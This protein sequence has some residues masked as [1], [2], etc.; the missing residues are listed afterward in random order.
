MIDPSTNGRNQ[1]EG[2]NIPATFVAQMG[3]IN[4]PGP[5]RNNLAE[6]GT[7]SPVVKLLVNNSRPALM[8]EPETTSVMRTVKKSAQPSAALKLRKSADAIKPAAIPAE[9]SMNSITAVM[10]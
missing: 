3:T 1:R 7:S 6:S 5:N 8:L 10:K 9:A 4:N 2:T